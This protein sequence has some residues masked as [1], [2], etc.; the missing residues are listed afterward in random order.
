VPHYV[1]PPPE[2]PTSLEA[3][4]PRAQ[5]IVI[6]CM[7]IRVDPLGALGYQPGDAHVLRNAGGVVTDDVARSVIVS[8]RLLGTTRVDVMGHTDCGAASPR[9]REV[10]DE[11]GRDLGGIDDLEDAVRASVKRLRADP[12]ILSDDV[13]GFLFDVVTGETRPVSL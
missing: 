9:T 1:N 3:K 6:T 13:R 10:S 12:D 5:A 7:D 8:Q 4:Q 2:G 11:I